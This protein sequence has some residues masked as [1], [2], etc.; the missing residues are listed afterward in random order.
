MYFNLTVLEVH[1]D[2]GAIGRLGHVGIEILVFP[3]FEV[4]DVVAVVQI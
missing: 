4:Q 1:L 3:A 2:R